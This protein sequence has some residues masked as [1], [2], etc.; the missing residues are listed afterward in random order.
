MVADRRGSEEGIVDAPVTTTDKETKFHWRGGLIAAAIIFVTGVLWEC[1]ARLEL[2]SPAFFPAPTVTVACVVRLLRSGELPLNAGVTLAR[3]FIGFGLGGVTGLCLGLG[4]GWSRRLRS[5][6]D[7][8]V[9]LVHPIPKIAVLPLVM[10]FLGIGD[11]SKVA[12]IALAAFFPV[13]INSMNGVKQISGEHFEVARNFRAG[14][15]KIFRR[16]VW[17]GSLPM[18]LTGT[19]LG[20]NSALVVT[21]AVEL[22]YA[23]RGLGAMVWRAWETMRMEELYAGILVTGLIGISFNALLSSVMHRLVPWLPDV[24]V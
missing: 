9:G 4:M 7:P 18:T 3:L 8:L 19:R 6:V 17:P 12:V 22:V 24:E 21:V 1:A 10:A 2:L 14:P 13:L 16:V 15:L 11:T 5:V 20:F 23:R